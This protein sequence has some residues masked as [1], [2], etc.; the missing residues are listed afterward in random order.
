MGKKYLIDTNILISYLDAKF[1]VKGMQFLN[2]IIDTLPQLSIISKM[3]ALG[4]GSI[5][6]EAHQLLSDFINGALIFQLDNDITD[7]TIAL[8]KT[9]RIKLPDAIIAATA[10]VNDF[11][12]LT[13]DKKDFKNIPGLNIINPW[14][15]KD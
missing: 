6:A 9:N 12:L 3:E 5:N 13:N 7:Q 11:I 2:E 14:D 8:R 4:Y 1:S 10:I 15:L